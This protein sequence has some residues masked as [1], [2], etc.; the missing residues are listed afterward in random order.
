MERYS[1][2]GCIFPLVYLVAVSTSWNMNLIVSKCGWLWAKTTEFEDMN[3]EKKK[4]FMAIG[5][6]GIKNWNTVSTIIYLWFIRIVFFF[7]VSFSSMLHGLFLS[8][9]LVLYLEYIWWFGNCFLLLWN[10]YFGWW[11]VFALLYSS[12]FHRL[13]R[14]SSESHSVPPIFIFHCCCT[15]IFFLFFIFRYVSVCLF[16][17]CILFSHLVAFYKSFVRNHT[18]TFQLNIALRCG[19][20]TK[21]YSQMCERSLTR[22]IWRVQVECFRVFRWLNCKPVW[23]WVYGVCVRALHSKLMSIKWEWLFKN[24]RLK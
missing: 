17:F 20:S 7:L 1:H 10:W 22:V 9:A 16:I 14:S 19:S 18:L 21:F 4:L 13:C 24:K 8:I 15:T 11:L 23:I 3:V 6:N 5:L 12:S 2:F